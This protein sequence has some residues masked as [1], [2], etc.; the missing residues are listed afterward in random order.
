MMSDSLTGVKLSTIGPTTCTKQCN[1]TYAAAFKEEQ[2][3]HIGNQDACNLLADGPQQEC[4]AAE[5]ARH[6]AAKTQLTADKISCQNN[7]HKQGT[8]SAG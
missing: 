5:S 2:K 1:D 6:E 7:C 3:T 8:G 4:K